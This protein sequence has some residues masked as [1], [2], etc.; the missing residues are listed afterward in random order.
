[1]IHAIIFSFLIVSPFLFPSKLRITMLSIFMEKKTH[2]QNNTTLR[3]YLFC[4][5]VILE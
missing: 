2:L 4:V 3:N 1:M 5:L